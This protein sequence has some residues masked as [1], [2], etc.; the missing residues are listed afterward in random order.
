M[1]ANGTK[2]NPNCVLLQNAPLGAGPLCFRVGLMKLTLIPRL[3]FQRPA[4][5]R[6][7]VQFQRRSVHSHH[8]HHHGPT[9]PCVLGKNATYMNRGM[10]QVAKETARLIDKNGVRFIRPKH[11]SISPQRFSYTTEAQET[12]YAFEMAASNIRF[13]RE[14]FLPLSSLW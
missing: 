7:L 2:Q 10:L 3:A 8:D 6:A 11:P 9:C 5:P 4:R 12:D 14:K 13:A 1:N